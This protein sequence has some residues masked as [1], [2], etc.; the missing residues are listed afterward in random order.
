MTLYILLVLFPLFMLVDA[1]GDDVEE[2]DL[3]ARL[4][5]EEAEEVDR[6]GAEEAEEERREALELG[7]REEEGRAGD[8]ERG[9]DGD[10]D[11]EEHEDDIDREDHEVPIPEQQLRLMHAKFDK[12]QDG[13]A[14]LKEMLDFADKSDKELAMKDADTL[15]SEA[16]AS[17]DGKVTLTEHLAFID[18]HEEKDLRAVE[19]AKFIAADTNGD[20]VLDKQELVGLYFPETQEGVLSAA[21]SATMS[22]K[23]QDKDGRLSLQ[24]FVSDSDS[25]DV[26]DDKDR[27]DFKLL[28]KDGDGTLNSQE[29]NVWESGKFH[30]EDTVKEL[31]KIA[32]TD[33]DL[34][35][36]ADE[37]VNARKQLVNTEAQHRLVEWAEDHEL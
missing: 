11:D 28:D 10:L 33:H 9:S 3:G 17:K 19:E 34:Y 27:A 14:S 29:L 1:Q 7:A 6:A 21:V 18:A 5:A 32:D 26:P 2:A 25:N 23:D 4:A 24:E 16:D 15:F 12:D 8:D 13:R 31:L 22:V 37:L 20:S 36:T 30:T 35:L